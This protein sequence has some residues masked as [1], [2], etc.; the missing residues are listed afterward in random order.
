MVQ[1]V[2]NKFFYNNCK[3]NIDYNVKES[4]TYKTSRHYIP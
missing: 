2:A 1:T 4:K 3:N